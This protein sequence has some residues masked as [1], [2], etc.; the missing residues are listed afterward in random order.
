[1]TIAILIALVL[2]LAALTIIIRVD[3]SIRCFIGRFYK[4]EGGREGRERGRGE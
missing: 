1:M 4:R 3:K 2:V